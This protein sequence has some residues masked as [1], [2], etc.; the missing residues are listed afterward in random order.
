ME[1]KALIDYS[2]DELRELCRQKVSTTALS[3]EHY[4]GELARRQQAQFAK[5]LNRWTVV[6]AIA[7]TVNTAAVIVSTAV[8]ILLGLKTLGYL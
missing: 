3:S 8:A 4:W 6:M 1:D 5:T 7:T 2:D